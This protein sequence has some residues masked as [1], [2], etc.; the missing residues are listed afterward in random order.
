MDII[1][2][3]V[4]NLRRKGFRSALTIISIA[5]GV[6]S[7][8]II[9]AIGD[10]GTQAVNSELDSLGIGGVMISANQGQT[11]QSYLSESDLETVS[12][13]ECVAQAVPIITGT[14]KV[15]GNGI[16]LDT[17]IWGVDAGVKQIISFDIK[18]GRGLN[19]RD[20][21]NSKNVCLIDANTA[22]DFY[23]RENIVGKKISVTYGKTQE[24]YEIVGIASADSGILQ[25]L[26]G[27]Y[28]PSFIYL[29]YTNMQKVSGMGGGITQIVV[30]IKSGQSMDLSTKMIEME[31]DRANGITG[32]SKIE[33]LV[34]QRDKLGNLLGIVTAVLSVIGGISLVVAGLGIMTAMLVSVN[35][36]TR[37]IGIKKS[38][39]AKK[40]HILFEFLLEATAISLIGSIIGCAGGIILI[41]IGSMLISIPIPISPSQLISCI[42]VAM[43]IGMLFGVYPAL[44]AAKLSPVDA[45]RRE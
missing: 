20:I 41:I 40:R 15:S 2:S 12:G 5:I 17:I 39:G 30:K 19:S 16:Y 9:N 22:M 14:G 23:K 18:Y 37:E 26:M 28:I 27:D 35:E 36:R 1:F 11:S 43:G 4:K 21:S 32:F 29:P 42:G 34:Q 45:L 25:G 8:V 33:N 7:V 38:I 10:A 44:K 3:S 13:L 24:E 6:A 31:L